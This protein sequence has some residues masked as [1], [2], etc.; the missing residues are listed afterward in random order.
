LVLLGT[1][2]PD[3]H[4]NV[5]LSFARINR[6]LF[7]RSMSPVIIEFEKRGFKE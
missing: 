2:S 7:S 1:S 6:G 4:C 3:P 5:Y